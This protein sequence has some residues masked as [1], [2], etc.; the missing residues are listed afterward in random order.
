MN[1]PKAQKSPLMPPGAR[2]MLGILVAM[3][4]AGVLA[5]ATLVVFQDQEP[6][7]TH[8]EVSGK[9]AAGTLTTEGWSKATGR[10]FGLLAATL[11]FFQFGLSSKP[12]PLDHIFGL[13]RVLSFHRSL[14][15]FLVILVA[16]H[17]LFM[18]ASPSQEIG[19]LR[20]AIWPKLL[21]ILLLIGLWTGVCAALWRRFLSLPY[22]NWYL[23]HR[24]GMFSAVVIF[25]LHVW[26]VTDDFHHGWPLYSLGAALLLYG[27]LFVWTL[28]FKPMSL[29]RRLFTVTRVEPVGKDIHAVELVPRDGEMF[30]YAP[31]Q[32]AFVTFLSEAV[33]VERHHWTLS[34]TPTRP[35]SCIF[36][37]KCSGDF[38]AF[39]GRLK[40]GDRAVV[41]GPYGLFSFLAHVLQSG[42]EL[43]MI[44]GGIGITP[45]LSML[46]YMA[47][48]G[49][50]RKVTLIW[51]NRTEAEILCRGEID[52]MKEK[53][54]NF[55]IH[56]VL[57]RQK[58][59][60]GPTGRLSAETLEKL[61]SGCGRQAA[62]FVCGP[63]PMMDA[64][65]RNLKRL[66]FKGSHIY[67][68]R[69]SY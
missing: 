47:D 22:Q 34:S 32:F 49:D 42:D 61:L 9:T 44:S 60:K 27:V 66:G 17:P 1:G 37:I 23:M 52:G 46:R 58:D 19:P 56:H 53:L 26:N 64:V 68:E 36:T 38:T 50:S 28:L 54:P 69:F 43:V 13:H 14:G 67:T 8:K 10:V 4:A 41:D 51:S 21:G 39:V 7:P 62:V 15:L 6:F 48:T 12:K 31:G 11:L 45:M 65:C 55:A 57:S 30:P 24:V 33:P 35:E 40:A 18:F 59:F 20:L 63:P 25:S 2:F 16:L 5:G 29:K 3:L